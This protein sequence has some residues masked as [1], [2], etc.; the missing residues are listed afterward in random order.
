ML[1]ARASCRAW[2]SHRAPAG[3]SAGLTPSARRA[4]PSRRACRQRTRGLASEHGSWEWTRPPAQLDYLQMRRHL[5]GVAQAGPE[6]IVA[7][8]LLPALAVVLDRF[9]GG[10]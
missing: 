7:G 2:T 1:A 6:P 4:E 9:L 10:G 8:L 3:P 5:P